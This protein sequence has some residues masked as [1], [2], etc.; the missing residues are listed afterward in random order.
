MS[1]CEFTINH[2]E[3]TIISE[4]YKLKPDI[5]GFSCYIWNIEM[6][7]N[8]ISSLK[9][10]LPNAIIVVGGHE[11]SYNFNK[12]KDIDFVIKG[13]GETAFYN[14]LECYSSGK[15]FNANISHPKVNLN[16]IPFIYDNESY[17][18]EG[19]ENKIIYYETSRGCPFS[20]SYCISSVQKSEVRFLDLKRIYNDLSFFLNQKVHQVK[21]I[22][23]TFNCNKQHALN[24][25][26]FLIDNDNG[27]TNFHF[28]ICAD[29]LD[30]EMFNVLKHARKGLFQF[31]IGIQSTNP[32][33]LC[34]INRSTKLEKVFK[35]IAE[36]KKIGN[37]HQHLDLI[38]GLP[39]ESY[40]SFKNSFNEVFALNP[41]QLQL[42]F[43]KVLK[44]TAIEKD[45]LKYGIVCKDKAN[46]EVLY[47]NDIAFNEIL[48]LKAIEEMVEIFYNSQRFK[49][50]IKFLI[51][52]FNSPFDFF[53]Q[54]AAY[55]EGNGYHLASHNRFKV[56][57]ILYNFLKSNKLKDLLLFD[58][59]SYENVK[60]IPEWLE[61]EMTEDEKKQIRQQKAPKMHIQKFNFDIL[62]YALG[63]SFEI[64]E[65][66]NFV[67]FNYNNKEI[68]FNAKQS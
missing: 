26:K 64:I 25:W 51:G 52:Q 4:L 5:I 30:N 17:G 36:I 7:L 20:C 47:T 3:N 48:K 63:K 59:L 42:G 58:L 57:E 8:I 16:D 38:A 49:N 54:L 19:T 55:W 32:K 60:S 27:I 2:K 68:S 28:E 1:I 10:V 40:N 23:R 29:L 18:L 24:I 12:T 56:L 9:K 22:D 11:V 43:L 67:I 39:L 65:K 15:Q 44:G 66:K 13:E 61:V 6:T 34:A 37:I 46:Y 45:A 35:N 21:F 53:E 33:T 41:E 31:E 50:S 62:N 14:L